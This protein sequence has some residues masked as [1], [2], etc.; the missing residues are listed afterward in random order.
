MLAKKSWAVIPHDSPFSINGQRGTN[1]SPGLWK[2]LA[3]IHNEPLAKVGFMMGES[4][5]Q[6]QQEG[7]IVGSKP[8]EKIA[9][10]NIE[11]TNRCNLGCS[12]CMRHVWDED[13]G[14]MDL[15][16]FGQ[17]ISGLAD[18]D[19]L[20]LL[21]LGGFGE[22]LSHP[23]I[24][25]M[26][27]KAKEKRFSVG[28]ITN[29]V[30]LDK[31][32]SSELIDLGL[33]RLWVSI[34]G[35]TPGSYEDVRLGDNL[36]RVVANLQQF[37]DLKV[38]RTKTLPNLGIAFVAMRKNIH[39]LPDVI[40]LGR[41]LGADRFSISNVLP[42]SLEL[43]EQILYRR[44]LDEL[45]TYDFQWDPNI[46]FPRIDL[47]PLV[48]NVL[49]KLVDKQNYEKVTRQVSAHPTR[50]C[51]FILDGSVSIRWDGAVSPCLP[52]LH[53]HVSYLGETFRTSK[54]CVLGNL[55]DVSL[56]DVW[57]LPEYISLRERLRIFDFSPCVLCNSC[58]MAETNQED[59]FGNIHPTCGGCLW[60]Q[61]FIQCP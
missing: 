39:D 48:Q 27:S 49:G 43:L 21:F 13:L 9:R 22:P 29:G 28:V 26:V 51:P 40:D 59:C 50:H 2:K 58:E 38:S 16:L 34:D 7:G 12:T 1:Q 25:T 3:A 53:S 5:L 8:L 18:C 24:L 37:H 56:Q 4:I 33:D 46:S 54:A 6:Q 31:D 30:L 61:G 44:S 60:A 35:A 10:V 32:I 20:P 36:P 15:Q 47:D 14:V 11:L 23:N 42:H 55:Y 17:I 52:L 41:S 57:I 45:E 19:P